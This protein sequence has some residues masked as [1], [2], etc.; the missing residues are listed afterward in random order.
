MYFC[1]LRTR[2]RSFTSCKSC[3]MRLATDLLSPGGWAP[4][5]VMTAL[6]KYLLSEYLYYGIQS[7]K[8][9]QVSQRQSSGNGLWRNWVPLYRSLRE[10]SQSPSGE[11]LSATMV[12]VTAVFRASQWGGESWAVLTLLILHFSLTSPTS[13]NEEMVHRC[14]RWSVCGNA[15]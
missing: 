5:W 4:E 10:S 11:F 7:Q 2:H 15:T 3:W 8:Y 1:S 12:T 6:I 14:L 13:Y 9:P